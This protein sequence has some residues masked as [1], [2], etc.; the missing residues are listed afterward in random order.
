MQCT[1]IK[2]TFEPQFQSIFLNTDQVK[3]CLSF[4]IR[5]F[6]RIFATPRQ[7]LSVASGWHEY[8]A[9]N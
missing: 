7:V 9:C 8:E 2:K 6:P 5:V 1:R 3:A 4:P